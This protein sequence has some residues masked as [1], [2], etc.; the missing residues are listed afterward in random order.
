VRD[1]GTN[2]TC[3]ILKYFYTLALSLYI[4]ILYKKLCKSA[5]M[6]FLEWMDFVKELSEASFL[7]TYTNRDEIHQIKSG[8]LGRCCDVFSMF[9]LSK[10]Q[11]WNLFGT[12]DPWRALVRALSYWYFSVIQEGEITV[13][14]CAHRGPSAR[15]ERHTLSL[16]RNKHGHNNSAPKYSEKKKE[17]LWGPLTTFLNPSWRFLESQ[18]C[19]VIKYFKTL[20]W[21]P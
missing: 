6:S 14:E 16:G 21:L 2:K 4:A 15:R 9:V 3:L 8:G 11:F 13:E 12:P 5:W 19:F 10:W 20:K 17:N 18:S 1:V 7:N